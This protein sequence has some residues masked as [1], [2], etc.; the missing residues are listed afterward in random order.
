M[1][2]SFD[3]AFDCALES[4]HLQFPCPERDT[5]IVRDPFGILTIILPDGVLESSKLTFF[6]TELHKKLGRFS[7]GIE[8]V[9]LEESDLIDRDDILDSRD[10]VYL[11]DTRRV[12]LVDRLITNQDWLREPLTS[13]PPLPTGVFFSLKGGVGRST[14]IAALAR[15]LSKH[16]KKVL[17]IDLDLEAP[18]VGGMMLI[19][20]AIPDLGFVDW[21]IESMTGKVGVELLERMIARSILMSGTPGDILVVP[22]YGKKTKNYVAKVGRVYMPSLA[23]AET[24]NDCSLST[25]GFADR[26]LSLL[27]A[28]R[29]SIDPPDVVLIDARAGLHDIGSAAI[30]QLGAEVF[31]FSRTDYQ[32]RQ[33]LVRLFDHL[34]LAR[35]VRFGMPDGDLRWH[36]KMVAAQIDGTIGSFSDAIEQSYETWEHFYDDE[37]MGFDATVFEKDDKD[38]PHYPLPITFDPRIRGVDFLDSMR[39]PT[40]EMMDSVFGEFVR[41]AAIR[42]FEASSGFRP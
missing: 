29:G 13:R 27:H 28:A 20:D 2:P 31:M 11:P 5:T 18:G 15:Y 21:C 23:K 16:G 40:D 22:A 35:S 34:K 41:K 19:E 42:I 38:A 25:Q 26:I 37:R 30:T 39:R 6:A 1:N 33:G 17:V 12:F 14:A 36:L 32:N 8:R 7:P 9:V 24:D 4:I 3:E 10:R